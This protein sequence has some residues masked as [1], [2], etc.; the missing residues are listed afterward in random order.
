MEEPGRPIASLWEN[1]AYTHLG[2]LCAS[3]LVSQKGIKVILR[4]DRVCPCRGNFERDGKHP[5][6]QKRIEKP[7]LLLL[8]CGFPCEL[9]RH[10]ELGARKSGLHALTLCGAGQG[11]VPMVPLSGCGSGHLTSV[12]GRVALQ[13]GFESWEQPGWF[14]NLIGLG[15]TRN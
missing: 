5:R 9:T 1:L 4:R 7:A 10:T 2:S 13:V 3:Q 12:E 15:R 8:E 14:V 11:A 6:G